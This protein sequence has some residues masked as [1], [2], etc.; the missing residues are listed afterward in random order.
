MP[1]DCEKTIQGSNR[2]LLPCT[3]SARVLAIDITATN[4]RGTWYQSGFLRAII[5]LD[6]QPFVGADIK[7]IFGQQVIELPFSNYQLD[8]APR[9]W[10]NSTTIKI[11]QL[12]NTQSSIFMG[13]NFAPNQA[14]VLA[15]EVVNVIPASVTSVTLDSSNPS[16]RDGFVVNKSNRNLWV[17]F[18]VGPAI[19]AAPT[20]LI[21]PGSNINIPEGYTGVISGI[22]SGPNPTASAEIHLFNAI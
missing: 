16:R 11:K 5:D 13:I 1:W 12:S 18:G 21:P 17:K 10:L 9:V 15:D 7:T 19:A 6:G 3:F 8:F 14:E 20:S 4:Q 2:T 22:W